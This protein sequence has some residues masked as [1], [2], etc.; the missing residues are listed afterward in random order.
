[1]SFLKWLSL[2]SRMCSDLLVA[3]MLIVSL[4]YS[5]GLS[6]LLLKLHTY[7]TRNE[8]WRRRRRRRKKAPL[9]RDSVQPPVKQQAP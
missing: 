9:R 4:K 3:K 2:I 5:H 1:M 7:P 6:L 8:Q